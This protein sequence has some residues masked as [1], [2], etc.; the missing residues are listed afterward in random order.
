IAS[1]LS[2][3]ISVI[4]IPVAIRTA[5]AAIASVRT[6]VRFAEAILGGVSLGATAPCQRDTWRANE[7]GYHTRELD[8]PIH[9]P[10]S[11]PYAAW[12]LNCGQRSRTHFVP[13]LG[14]QAIHV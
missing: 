3:P 8:N 14:P 5:I 9:F 2:H 4:V 13:L 6:I 12:L 1:I 11:G 10:P 7:Q